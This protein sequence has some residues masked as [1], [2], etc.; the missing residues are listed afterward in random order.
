[1][2]SAPQPP[3][4]LP[5]CACR[6]RSLRE[7]RWRTP[8]RCAAGLPDA[9]LPLALFALVG[10]KTFD[11]DFVAGAVRD[12]LIERKMVALRSTEP[13]LARYYEVALDDFV[14]QLT[15]PKDASFWRGRFAQLVD[16]CEYVEPRLQTLRPP[17]LV[18][19]GTADAL[20]QSEAEASRLAER[21][22]QCAV[23]LVQGAGHAGTLDLRIDLPT[24]LRDW[25]ASL[26]ASHI[27]P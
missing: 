5:R 25:M 16:G 17:T 12:V 2:R 24:V 27:K 19:A 21:I 26:D 18:V 1:M 15:S 7:D 10:R 9:L 6:R 4:S 23:H 13:E 11:V 14:R 8:P 22:P 3:I 20:L